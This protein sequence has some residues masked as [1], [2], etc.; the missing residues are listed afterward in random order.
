MIGDL[1]LTVLAMAFAV[2]LVAA[3]MF[4]VT[5]LYEK[6]SAAHR[7]ARIN[8]WRRRE[9]SRVRT[10]TRRE[11]YRLDSQAVAL[12]QQLG[13]LARRGSSRQN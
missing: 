11:Q 8:A 4:A 2:A 13:D 12:R 7:P 6:V 3:A 1:V 5:V 9:L 10:A